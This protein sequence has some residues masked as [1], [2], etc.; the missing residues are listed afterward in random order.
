MWMDKQTITKIWMD[1][2]NRS[3]KWI[4]WME[5]ANGKTNSPI[6]IQK[7]KP[8]Q[9]TSLFIFKSIFFNSLVTS[10]RPPLCFYL[11]YTW[12]SHQL[13]DFV[14]PRRRR[15][16]PI[17]IK[18]ISNLIQFARGLQSILTKDKEFKYWLPSSTLGFNVVV[19]LVE[20]LES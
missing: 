16:M 18:N 8:S 17:I 6:L 14:D 7:V 3:Y 9:W 20:Y 1:H 4:I 11:K 5:M 15:S 12:V 10:S 19:R 13:S 2:L